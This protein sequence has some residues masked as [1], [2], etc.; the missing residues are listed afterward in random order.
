LDRTNDNYKVTDL[1]LEHNHALHLPETLHLMASQ[2]KFSNLQAF[3]IETADNAGIGPK[4]AHELACRQVGGPL[5][6]SYTLRDHKKYSER[7][8]MAKQVACLN[9]FKTTLLKTYHFSMHCKWTDEQIQQQ[10]QQHSLL[11]QASWG[12]LEMKPKRDEKQ[13]DT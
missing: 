8:H 11:S 6:L 10:Q 2:R 1:V 4:A 9:I 3:E 5:N 12:R 13:R 7:W